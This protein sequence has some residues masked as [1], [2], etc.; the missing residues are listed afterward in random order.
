MTIHSYTRNGGK[1][2]TYL[3][4]YFKQ[5][6]AYNVTADHI[7]KGLKMVAAAL[8]YPSL[9]GI[10]IDRIDLHSLHSGG[11]NALALSG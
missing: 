1:P 11:A 4:T 8:N 9:K 3:S 6:T 2:K 10:P 7:S 5:G